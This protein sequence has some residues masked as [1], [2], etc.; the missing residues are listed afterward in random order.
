MKCEKCERTQAPT[1]AGVLG[2]ALEELMSSISEDHWAAS[3]MSGTEQALWR[4]VGEGCGDWGQ[5][6]VTTHEVK[7]LRELAELS[8][9]WWV[10]G[11]FVSLIGAAGLMKLEPWPPKEGSTP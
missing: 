10:D 7:R 1:D 5:G 11:H 3:W 8:G 2:E 4:I 6:H 9:G